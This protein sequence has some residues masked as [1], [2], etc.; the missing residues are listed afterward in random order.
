MGDK[1]FVFDGGGSGDANMSALLAGLIGKNNLDPNMVAALMNNRHDGG[2]GL[3]GGN[4]G[5]DALLLIIL[6]A[7]VGRGGGLF[8]GNEAAAIPAALHGDAGRELIMN[9]VRGNSDA[10]RD[11]ASALNTS[12]QNVQNSLC[13]I[14][15]SI[16]QLSGQV[17]MSGQQIINSIQLG[18]NTLASQLAQCC[19]D[20]QKLILQQGADDRLAMCQQTNTLTNAGTYN[21]QRVVDRIDALEKSQLMDKL[22]AYREKN[23]VLQNE[24]SQRNQNDFIYRQTQ[25]IYDR[26]AAIECKQLPT[27]PQQFIPGIPTYG[28]A[29]PFCGYGAPFYGGHGH[30]GDCGDN[31]NW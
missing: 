7:L 8:G 9:A 21:T 28:Y 2:G 26:L 15:N 10:I 17:G 30:C 5:G 27:Y 4:G 18:N 12:V 1:T 24:I 29:A 11:L 19:C 6:L 3:F 20:T 25:P 22:D 23:A 13:C 31:R 14:N 16:T